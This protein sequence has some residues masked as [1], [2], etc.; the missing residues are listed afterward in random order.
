VIR[1]DFTLGKDVD[2]EDEFAAIAGAKHAIGVGSGTDALFRLS[3]RPG[4]DKGDE[5]ITTPTPRHDR[6]DR[7]AGAKPVSSISVTTTTW[8]LQIDQRLR[9]HTRDL[10][11]HWSG[12]PCDMDLSWN[13]IEMEPRRGRRCGCR[14]DPRRLPRGYSAP[15]CFSFHPSR[16]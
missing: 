4:A 16:I 7:H 14:Q 5:V 9:L 10:A 8:T 1:G 12:K 11:V 3:R 13:R 2:L 6:R 15:G